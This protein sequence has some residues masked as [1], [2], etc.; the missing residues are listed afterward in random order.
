[1]LRRSWLQ[2]RNQLVLKVDVANL[3]E[4]CSIVHVDQQL[5]F[6]DDGARA[7]LLLLDDK[8]FEVVDGD[9]ALTLHV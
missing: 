2:T 7:A 4:A 6:V 1:M 8:A 5:D 9:G 3:V